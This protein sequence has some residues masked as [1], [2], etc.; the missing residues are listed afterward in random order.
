[1]Q[2][3]KP[4]EVFNLDDF[5]PLDGEDGFEMMYADGVLNLDIFYETDDSAARNAR[6]GIRFLQTKYFLKTPFSGYSFF[7]CPDDR[8]LSL[9]N[10]VV[11]YEYSDMLEMEQ[12]NS[13]STGYKHYRL[14]LHSV[15]VALHVIAQSC[16][17][18]SEEL[19]D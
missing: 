9:L 1:M 13:G 16:E 17:I 2:L 8:D 3:S 5:L 15:G 10:S 12:K 6:R 19:I 14:F 4:K 18:S 7:S 11:E